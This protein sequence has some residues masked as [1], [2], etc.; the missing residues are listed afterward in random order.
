MTRYIIMVFAGACCFGILSTFVKVAYHEGYSTAD[1]SGSQACFGMLVLWALYLL[2]RQ[3]SPSASQPHTASWK[4]MLAGTSIGLCTHLYYLSVQWI[5]ASVAIIFLMQF[6]WIGLLLEWL[7]YGKR[8]SLLQG[9]AAF[10]IMTGTIMASGMSIRHHM[11]LPVKG[12]LLAIAAATVYGI[13]IVA[14]GRI[15]NEL[16]ALKKSAL[17]MT[18]S[19]AAIFLVATPGFLFMPKLLSGLVKWTIF[20]G[21][22]GTIIPPLL[23]SAGIPKTG[24]ILSAL[25]MT[26]ELPV[27]VITARLV[28]HEH[29]SLL[30]WSGVVLMLFAMALPP[31]QQLA[32][33]R[34]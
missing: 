7:I 24:V 18:G 19:T 29:I 4:V 26:V 16:P 15:G 33:K 5:P 9:I 20:L 3:K 8:P 12:V 17:I 2:Q 21:L 22:F 1:I 14:S 10:L 13:Y 11:A 27:A 30:Q 23:F 34:Q 28:L 31:L 32:A 6:T 25:L